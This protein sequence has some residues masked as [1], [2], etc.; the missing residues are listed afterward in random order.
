MTKRMIAGNDWSPASRDADHAV[1]GSDT[2]RPVSAPNAVAGSS[3]HV[4]VSSKS[5]RATATA[6]LV[7]RP[8][9][10]CHRAEPAAIWPGSSGVAYIA[11]N[12]YDHVKPSMI[13]HIAS[14]DST[15]IDVVAISAG[16]R[17]AR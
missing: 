1:I 6:A 15:I 12:A 10:A 3:P 4:R 7:R 17:K 5:N 13:G 9:V 2:A 16:A 14:W 8:R 11:R